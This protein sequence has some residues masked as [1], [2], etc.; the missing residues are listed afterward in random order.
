[1]Y[2]LKVLHIYRCDSYIYKHNLYIYRHN[3]YIYSYS[4]Y[5]YRC[6]AINTFT[7]TIYTFT[8]TIYTFTDIVYPFT[9]R[10]LLSDS[11]KILN[12]EQFDNGITLKSKPIMQRNSLF[13]K[14]IKW[15]ITYKLLQSFI[16]FIMKRFLRSI[17]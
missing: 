6:M 4:L 9:D 5:I 7:S 11:N 2:G 14:K 10:V 3:L 16:I 12:N 15:I 13:P 1:M 17:K 8:D